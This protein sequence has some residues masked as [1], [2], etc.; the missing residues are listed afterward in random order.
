[1]RNAL[2][3]LCALT[4]AAIDFSDQDVEIISPA[5][6]AARLHA[7][8]Q[9][10]SQMRAGPRRCLT[11]DAVTVAIVGPPNV[12]KSSLLNALVARYADEGRG[13][14]AIVSHVPGTTRD[15]LEARIR[16]QGIEFRLIDTAGLRATK[17][18][19]EADAV[20]RARAA[21]EEAQLTLHV[22]DAS[23][24]TRPVPEPMSSNSNIIMVLNKVDLLPT[25]HTPVRNEGLT[26]ASTSRIY[27]SA[28]TGQGVDE[29]ARRMAELV[30]AGAVDRSG[31]TV[32]ANARQQDAL[33][34]AQEAVAAAARNL[35]SGMALELAAFEMRTGLNTLGEIIGEVTTEDLLDKIFGQFCIGK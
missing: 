5:N 32:V 4:E 33:A 22:L 13:R 20:Q 2:S 29:L 24:G 27:T 9:R 15:T 16:V 17:D 7:L 28:V 1:V 35:E 12:G 21:Q 26:P 3:D 6:M 30:L 18:D 19:V 31:S 34:R 8:A 10:L 14:R 11:G 25:R 23:E